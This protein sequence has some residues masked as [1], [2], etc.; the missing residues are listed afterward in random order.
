MKLYYHPISPFVRKVLVVAHENGLAGRIETVLTDTL[1]ERLRAINPLAKIPAL[2]LED[3]TVLYDSRVICEYLDAMG[4]GAML[5]AAGEA[6]WRV[7]LLEALGDGVADGVLRIVM[8][9]RRPEDDRHA[10]V[11]V[12]QQRAVMAGLAEAERQLEP[13]RF[14]LG[15]AAVACAI[16]YL[17]MRLP[18]QHWRAAHPRLAAW[19]DAALQRPSLALTGRAAA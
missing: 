14:T 10:D 9:N 16:G 19:Y 1:D 5:P 12:R 17:E 8:E 15:E 2:A 11:I 18:Q 7:R 6:R 13:G 4:P 3:G